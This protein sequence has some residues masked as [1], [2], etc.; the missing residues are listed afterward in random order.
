MLCQQLFEVVAA[1]RLLE[2]IIVEGKALDYELAQP[3]CCPDAEL[4]A[5]MGFYTVADRDDDLKVV[6]L[7]VIDFSIIGSYPEFPDN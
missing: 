1:A 2:P 6:V 5:T 3:L 4:R 7:R